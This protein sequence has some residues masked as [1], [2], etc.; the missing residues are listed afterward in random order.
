MRRRRVVKLYLGFAWIAFMVLVYSAGCAGLRPEKQA[1]SFFMLWPEGDYAAM[2]ELL[3]SAS[4]ESYTLDYFTER[5][6]KISGGIGLQDIEIK[7][8]IRCGSEEN[9]ASLSLS[10]SLHTYTVGIIPVRYSM[11]MSREERGAPWLLEWHPRLILPE[12]SNERKVDLRRD[13]PRRGMITDRKGEILAGPVLLKEVGAVAGRYENEAL[14]A[15]D[16]GRL[17]GLPREMIIEKLN[18]PWVREGFYVP[19]ALLRAEKEYLVEELIQI[20][21]VM[22]REVESRS[23]PQGAAAAHLTGYMGAVTAEEIVENQDE[24]CVAGDLVGKTGLEAVLEQRLAGTTGYS[25]HIVEED[26]SE[27]ALIAKRDALDGEDI[28]LTIDMG[29]QNYAR[30]ALEGKKGA[31]VA[32]NPQ[33]GELLAL[34]SSPGYDPNPFVTGLSGP[35]WQALQADPEMP[36]LDRALSGLYPPGSAL[37]P[38]TAAAAI[39]EKAIDPAEKLEIIGDKWQLSD[40]WGD[41]YI[42]RV[43][44]GLKRVDLN[45]A[46][47][48]SDNIYFARAGLALGGEN[49]LSYGDRFGFGGEIDFLLPAASSSLAYQGIRSEVQLADS[50]YGQGEVMVTPLQMALMYSAFAAGGTIPRPQL[51]LEEEAAPWKESVISSAVVETV[52]RTLVETL[53][54]EGAPAAAG[55]IPGFTVAGKTGTA[56]VPGGKGNCCW[57]VTYGPAQSPGIVVAVVIEEGKMAVTEALP[58]GCTVLE[59]YLNLNFH[60]SED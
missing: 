53:H 11:E 60:P 23:Y 42:K 38:F 49:F 29:L 22:F 5:Y 43:Y 6:S 48:F 37:K 40:A 2:Y 47:K 58:V 34:F 27:V 59:Y 32:L 21:G 18:Q 9:R 7:E 8:V 20:P 52:H 54:G 44:K 36:L 45:E 19:L 10:L 31:V 15:A 33:N 13:F 50:S 30:E 4:R 41:Y 17:L 24:G 12:L 1:E 46:M 3:D 26:G 51:L 39:A 57:Y 55:I 28:A 56:E 14:F 16:V 35:E 25:L